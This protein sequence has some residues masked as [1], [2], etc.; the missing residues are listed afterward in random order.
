MRTESAGDAMQPIGPTYGCP[1]ANEANAMSTAESPRE[2]PAL[3][4]L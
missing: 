2:V 4:K 1:Q 3:Q